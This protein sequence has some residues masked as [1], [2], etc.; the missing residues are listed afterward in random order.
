MIVRAT[1]PTPNVDGKLVGM[2]TRPLVLPALLVAGLLVPCAC[3]GAE[4]VGPEVVGSATAFPTGYEVIVGL[5]CEGCESVFD[6]LPATLD[7]QARIAP[8]E[9]P[10][11]P[12][13]I[14][15]TVRDAAGQA[16]PG[17]VVYAYHTDA[18]GV[19]PPGNGAR[20]EEAR[21]H[22]RLRGWARSDAQG[23]YRFD[24]IRPASYP[25]TDIP[26]H[27]HMHVIEPGRCTYYIDDIHFADDPL[28]TPAQRRALT[29]GRGG[30]GVVQPEGDGRGGWRVRRDIALGANVPGHPGPAPAPS[31]QG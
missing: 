29:R 2:R 8:V 12:L 17:V 9:E 6:G 24:T 31:G 3:R 22:G 15:G 4:P 25:D 23:R 19:Y 30:E 13:V 28:L 5:P 1:A 11:E 21:R 7:A 26:Q 10:G 18:H 27:V 16:V 14:E 20:G